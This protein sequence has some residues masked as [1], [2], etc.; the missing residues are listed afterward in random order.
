MT[1]WTLDG[2]AVVA[3]IVAVLVIGLA[4]LGTDQP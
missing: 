3:L 1:G 4:L 2:V